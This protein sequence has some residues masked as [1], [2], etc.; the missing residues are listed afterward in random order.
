MSKPGGACTLTHCLRHVGPA[1]HFVALT[2]EAPGMGHCWTT[3]TPI[4]T[5]IVADTHAPV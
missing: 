5:G 1:A 2:A 4:G 3:H